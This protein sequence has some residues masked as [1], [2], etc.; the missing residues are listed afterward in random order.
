MDGNQ[1]YI[2]YHCPDKQHKT[3]MGWGNTLYNNDMVMIHPGFPQYAVPEELRCPQDFHDSFLCCVSGPTSASL[4]ILVRL[5]ASKT[6]FRVWNAGVKDQIMG[7]DR[8]V[9]GCVYNAC[10]ITSNIIRMTR[11]PVRCCSQCWGDI[12]I[13]I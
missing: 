11:I 7:L 5:A 13:Y 12:R 4:K 3:P 2:L 9:Q 6:K 10:G 1:Y 8:L